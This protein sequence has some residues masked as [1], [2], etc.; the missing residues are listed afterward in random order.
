MKETVKAHSIVVGLGI[1]LSVIGIVIGAA[2]FPNWESHHDFEMKFAKNVS[3]K[4]SS[5]YAINAD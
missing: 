1:I 5:Y 4:Y 3:E 2:V